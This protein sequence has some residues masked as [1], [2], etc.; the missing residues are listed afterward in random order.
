MNH[1]LYQ[2]VDDLAIITLN[3][4]E[5]AKWFPYPNV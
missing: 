3:R 2:I 5:V 4:P 1:I